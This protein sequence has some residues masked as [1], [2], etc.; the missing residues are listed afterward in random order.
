[1]LKIYKA[2]CEKDLG[3]CSCLLFVSPAKPKWSLAPVIAANLGSKVE[4]FSVNL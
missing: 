4:A 3:A 2:R 1:M